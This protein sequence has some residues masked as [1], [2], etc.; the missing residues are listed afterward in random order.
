MAAMFQAA[1]TDDAVRAFVV[2]G[3]GI[4]AAVHGA[5]GW[6]GGR[7]GGG[8]GGRAGVGFFNRI[9]AAEAVRTEAGTLARELAEGPSFANAMTKRKLHDGVGDVGRAGDRG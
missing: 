9:V 1:A 5:G 4:G 3:A 6:G 7:A 2:T 8:G